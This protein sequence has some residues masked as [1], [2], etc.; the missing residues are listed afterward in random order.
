MASTY[1]TARKK[2][3]EALVKKLKGIIGNHPYNSNVFN[4]VHPN[5]IFL[6]QIQEYPK[7]CVVAGDE[8]REYQPNEFKWRF[9]RLDIRVYVENQEDPQ[10]VLA[11]L[12][13]DI[14]RVIDENDVLIYDDTVSPNLTTTSLTLE[15]LSTDEG[16]LNPLGIGELTLVCR[17]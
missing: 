7:V 5:M 4:N 17:Y 15:S 13:E 6:D 1:R 10:E 8:S 3:V 16:V 11:L 14:E 12:M 2:I 9:L